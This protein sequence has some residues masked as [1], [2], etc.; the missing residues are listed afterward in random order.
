M[1]NKE[2][3]LVVEKKELRIE[4]KKSINNEKVKAKLKK[5][6]QKLIVDLF[7]M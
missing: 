5:K 2:V 4:L 1:N 7:L 3:K 6:V